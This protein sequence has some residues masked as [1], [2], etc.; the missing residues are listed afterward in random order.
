MRKVECP[1]Y[2]VT[3]TCQEHLMAT[4]PIT[5]QIGNGD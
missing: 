2:G 5:F 1:F 3:P 4:S